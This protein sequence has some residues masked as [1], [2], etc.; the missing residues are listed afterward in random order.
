[1]NRE[2]LKCHTDISTS[3]QSIVEFLGGKINFHKYQNTKIQRRAIEREFEII[4]EAISRILKEDSNFP[5]EK[6]KRVVN[7]RNWVIHGYDKVD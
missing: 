2:I 5:I 7:F 6:A 1:M 3:I 4:G